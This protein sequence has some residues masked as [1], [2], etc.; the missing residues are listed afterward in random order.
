MAYICHHCAWRSRAARAS[1]LGLAFALV[2]SLVHA[3]PEEPDAA[4]PATITQQAPR[5]ES[6]AI[7]VKSLGDAGIKLRNA[8]D[9][10]EDYLGSSAAGVGDVN[11]DGYAD[12]AIGS[13]EAD[14]RN[15]TVAVV[16]GGPRKKLPRVVDVAGLNGRNGFRIESDGAGVG[17]TLGGG[18]DIDGD[19]L[20]DIVIAN[21]FRSTT[22][23][24]FGRKTFPPVIEYDLNRPD[25]ASSVRIT[26]ANAPEYSHFGRSAAIIGDVNGDG[27]DDVAIGEVDGRT[28]DV[29]TGHAYV[30]FGRKGRTFPPKL[31]VSDLDGTNGFRLDGARELE[32]AGSLVAAAGDVNADGIDDFLVGASESNPLSR[33][34]AGVLYVV[35]GRK[36]AFPRQMKLGDLDGRTGFAIPGPLPGDSLGFEASA[37][38]AGDVNG[39]GIDDLTLT[40]A[41]R[42][43]F[44]VFGA[45]RKSFAKRF[46]LRTLNGQNGFRTKSIRIQAAGAGDMNG[47]GFDDVVFLGDRKSVKTHIL[48]GQKTFPNLV[49]F[50]ETKGVSVV[51]ID[52]LPDSGIVAP[53]GDIDRDGRADLLIGTDRMVI[54]RVEGPGGGYVLFGQ[55]WGK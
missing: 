52:G 38:A 49:V 10:A 45:R 27:I 39:D 44:V 25:K 31:S 23:I 18:G 9:N 16:F 15:G 30:V 12:V 6:A 50:G 54:D 17:R 29:R 43:G 47:D 42:A 19:G 4:E 51:R 40:A 3:A 14:D 5:R 35:F 33:R 37:A 20:D 8:T 1:V 21:E 55:D 13:Q 34:G 46:D 28:A 22:W 7:D 48:L 24:L 11:G 36:G 41:H 2:A 53:A 26:G 32:Y